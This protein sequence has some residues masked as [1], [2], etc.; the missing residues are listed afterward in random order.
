[1]RKCLELESFKVREMHKNVKK[2]CSLP[3][4]AFK[5]IK[6]TFRSQNN[7]TIEI[8]TWTGQL[9]GHSSWQNYLNGGQSNGKIHTWA[10]MAWKLWKIKCKNSTVYSM[11]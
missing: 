7:C 10:L 9:I 5:F 8:S 3:S 6:W 2:E 11:L 4:K 1:M